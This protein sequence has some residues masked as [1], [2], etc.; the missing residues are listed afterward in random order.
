MARP[1]PPVVSRN[2]PLDFYSPY[3]MRNL[4]FLS[5]RAA[6]RGILPTT[7]SRMLPDTTNTGAS[8]MRGA[9]TSKPASQIL[10]QPFEPMPRLC[11]C[12]LANAGRR[13]LLQLSEMVLPGNHVQFDDLSNLLVV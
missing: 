6:R 9:N 5:D 3:R 1:R 12:F 13:A 4:L 7:S 8:V 10:E 11:G 2:H